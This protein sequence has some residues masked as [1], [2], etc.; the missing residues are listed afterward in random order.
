MVWIFCGEE[1]GGEKVGMEDQPGYFYSLLFTHDS[2]T[3]LRQSS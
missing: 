2:F 3:S 1:G